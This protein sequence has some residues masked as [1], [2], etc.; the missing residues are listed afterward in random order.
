MTATI[1]KEVKSTPIT[2]PE[3]FKKAK[4]KCACGATFTMGATRPELS[5]EI[6]SQ[7]HPFYTGKEKIIDTAGRVEK[8]KARKTKADTSI[9]NK[10][11][12]KAEKKTKKTSKTEK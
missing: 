6:C 11:V 2:K 7:C 1:K 9:K 4:V 8:F 5:V 3:Y 10:A 12:K